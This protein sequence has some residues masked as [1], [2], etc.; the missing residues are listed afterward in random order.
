MFAVA[1]VIGV[2]IAMTPA[3]AADASTSKSLPAVCVHQPLFPGAQLEV[4]YCPN[5]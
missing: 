4:G 1:A 5:G 2:A 3:V